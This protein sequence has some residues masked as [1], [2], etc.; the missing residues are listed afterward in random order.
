M[1]TR[2]VQSQLLLMSASWI[3][4]GPWLWSYT[5]GNSENICDAG[6]VG[7]RRM[8]EDCIVRLS[9][10]VYRNVLA[11]VRLKLHN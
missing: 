5:L 3:A 7:C 1:M 8:D 10:F 9:L 6:W 4:E 2:R 11:R